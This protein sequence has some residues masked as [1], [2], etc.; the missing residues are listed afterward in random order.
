M[1]V[2]IMR[3]L[4][5]ALL[6]LTACGSPEDPTRAPDADDGGACLVLS[7]YYG[8][9][10]PQAPFCPYALCPRDYPVCVHG[11]CYENLCGEDDAK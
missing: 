4:A 8:A 11:A 5:I 1:A 7:P 6:A 3:L 10:G 9:A 2:E